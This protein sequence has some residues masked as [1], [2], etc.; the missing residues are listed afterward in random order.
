M[1]SRRRAAERAP[2]VLQ[3]G[4]IAP[5][6]LDACARVLARHAVRQAMESMG[7]IGLDAGPTIGDDAGNQHKAAPSSV[8]APNGAKEQVL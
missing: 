6:N 8:G 4:E 3:V 5:K 7:L 2:L 1:T